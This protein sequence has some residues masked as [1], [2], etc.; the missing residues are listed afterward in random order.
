M[1]MRALT[2]TCVA[3]ACAALAACGGAP[4]ARPVDGGG[5]THN[6]DPNHGQSGPGAAAALSG[7]TLSPALD[8]GRCLTA[9]SDADGTALQ[10]R[11][12]DGSEGQRVT[13]VGGQL[14]MFGTMCLDVADGQE[15]VSGIPL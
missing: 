5:I 1:D 12:C 13:L 6:P 15:S 7:V 4:A 2:H 10:L 3:L 14:R 9:P 11:A 8:V